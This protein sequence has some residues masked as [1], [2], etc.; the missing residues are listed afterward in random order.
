MPVRYVDDK[1]NEENPILIMKLSRNQKLDFTCIAKKGIAKTHA[2]WSPVATCILRAEPIVELDQSKIQKLTAEHKQELVS[3]CPRKVYSYNQMR[4]TVDI[5]NA[6]ACNLCGECN[7]YIAA[8]L[9]LPK[10]DEY[11]Q[12]QG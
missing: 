2:K 7:K 6:D 9:D 8:D 5:E 12:Y 4:E 1:G 3:R 11:K 10:N